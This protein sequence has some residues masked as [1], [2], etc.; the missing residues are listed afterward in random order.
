MQPKSDPMKHL[1][2]RVPMRFQKKSI[3]IVWANR[4]KEKA[5]ER[6]EKNTR[7]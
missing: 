3:R 1:R 5:K 7:K 4:L 6:E 2:H